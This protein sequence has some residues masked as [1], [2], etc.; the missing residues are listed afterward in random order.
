MGEAGQHLLVEMNLT[1]KMCTWRGQAP[2]RLRW[3]ERALLR[4]AASAAAAS[5]LVS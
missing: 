1:K 3:R 5:A 2:K 4:R